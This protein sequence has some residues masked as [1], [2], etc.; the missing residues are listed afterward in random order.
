METVSAEYRAMTASIQIEVTP[1]RLL[2]DEEIPAQLLSR[3]GP[4]LRELG[5][6]YLR[7]PFARKNGH[8]EVEP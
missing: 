4:G 3:I 1:V 2:I 7:I 6:N 5:A 8:L